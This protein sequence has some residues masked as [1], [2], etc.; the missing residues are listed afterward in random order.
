MTRCTW[1][2]VLAFVCFWNV[3]IYD[4]IFSC[5]YICVSM[6]VQLYLYPSVCLWCVYICEPLTV[7]TCPSVCALECF[8]SGQMSLRGFFREGIYVCEH[9]CAAL[10]VWKYVFTLHVYLCA[11]FWLCVHECMFVPL[12]VMFVSA[13]FR[14]CIFKFV[15]VWFCAWVYMFVFLYAYFYMS[16]R[17]FGQCCVCINYTCVKVRV[18]Q[19]TYMAY[20][21]Y[22]CFFLYRVTRK[23]GSFLTI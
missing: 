3:K 16:W 1:M 18:L 21:V 22:V 8:L 19:F 10:L 23:K 4:D 6:F 2:R 5:A 11:C 9:I 17:M 15:C 12:N 7:C 14:E 20:C 13:W